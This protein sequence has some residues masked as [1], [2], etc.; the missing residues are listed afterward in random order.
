MSD[1]VTVSSARRGGEEPVGR[2]P[3]GGRE[4]SAAGGAGGGD[5]L[6]CVIIGGRVVWGAWDGCD[7]D[8][9]AEDGDKGDAVA[10][11]EMGVESGGQK[12]AV[13]VGGGSRDIVS[14]RAPAHG[15]GTATESL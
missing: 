3:G 5:R 1:G 12:D 2:R 14:L 7:A 11:A 13:A 15:P 9:G 6:K 4:P 10:G 8:V